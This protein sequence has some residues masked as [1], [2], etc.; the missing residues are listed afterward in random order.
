MIT[1][2]S[3][4]AG[5]E[6]GGQVWVGAHVNQEGVIKEGINEGGVSEARMS[7]CI[8]EQQAK[9]TSGTFRAAGLQQQPAQKPAG[10]VQ[11]CL[12]PQALC[13]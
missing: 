11:T 13:T 8:K 6:T 1:Q 10:R 5:F 12:Q 7:E 2:V 3:D 4:W 9:D